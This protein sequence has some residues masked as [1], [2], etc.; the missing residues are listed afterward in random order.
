MEESSSGGLT[1]GEPRISADTTRAQ[2][3]N[4][5][6]QAK[7]TSARPNI[8]FG[9]QRTPLLRSPEKVTYDQ[10]ADWQ[11]FGNRVLDDEKVSKPILTLAAMLKLEYAVK[12]ILNFARVVRNVMRTEGVNE[13]KDVIPADRMARFMSRIAPE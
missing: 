12:K 5:T 2:S 9:C 8:P 10:D 3:R 6:E 13:P 1:R 11:E 7:D 4:E